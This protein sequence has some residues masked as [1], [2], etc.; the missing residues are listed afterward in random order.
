MSQL[1]LF[2]PPVPQLTGFA[3]RER[4]CPGCGAYVLHT[5]FGASD[6]LQWCYRC[7]YGRTESL[8][9]YTAAPAA[10]A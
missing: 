2:L 1:V 9:R 5:V 10:Y 6:L 8:A 7:P 4:R 3:S